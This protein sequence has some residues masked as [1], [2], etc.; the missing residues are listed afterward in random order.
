MTE[1][2][3]PRLDFLFRDPLYEV[4]FDWLCSIVKIGDASILAAELHLIEYYWSI[5]N[6]DNRGLD[7]EDLRLHFVDEFGYS[8]SDLGV[9]EERGVSMFEVLVALARRMDFIMYEEGLGSRVNHWFWELIGNMGLLSFDNS[10]YYK[11]LWSS[12]DVQNIVYYILDRKYGRDGRGGLFPLKNSIKD[13]R[14]VELWYQMNL[15]L[16]ENYDVG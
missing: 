14:K 3:D 9:L 10:G 11:V 5:P 6:D 13:Q 7:A 12:T 4:Y 16:A 2:N 8:D 1:T 15:Y